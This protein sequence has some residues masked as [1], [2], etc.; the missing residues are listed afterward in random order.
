MQ[1]IL[2]EAQ[3]CIV[4]KGDKDLEIIPFDSFVRVNHVACGSMGPFFFNSFED[5]LRHN[6][7]TTQFMYLS[8][9]FTDF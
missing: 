4:N 8:V 6:S 5:I 9:H 2:A 1:E 3:T 7:Y